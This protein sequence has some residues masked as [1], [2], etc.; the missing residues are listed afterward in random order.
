MFESISDSFGS[1]FDR[2]RGKRR[3]SED[4]IREAMREI[5]VALLEA[6]VASEV[7]RSFVKSVT[8]KSVDA[9]VV[10]SV[11]P[12]EMVV[13]IV[14]DELVELLGGEAVPL[15]LEPKGPTVM[16]LC[17]LQGAGKTTT[18]GKLAR[19]LQEEGHKVLLVGADVQRPAAIEQLKVL[20]EQIG[21]PVYAEAGGDPV[22]V[23]TRS[24]SV[25][26]LHGADVILL[27]TA[28]RL[29]VDE[30]L[31]QEL[32]SIVRATGP[33]EVLLVLDAMTGQDAVASAE[34]FSRRLP[35]SGAILTK[36]DGDARGGAAL[37]LRQVAGVPIKFVGVGEKLD[38]LEEFHP[39]RMAGRILGMGDVVS[40]V[41]KAQREVDEEEQKAMQEKL[42]KNS[43]TLEDFQK[44]LAQI[45]RMGS[46]KDLLGLI[47]GLGRQVRQID[48]DESEFQRIEA[49][50][51]SMTR[52]ERSEPEIIDT[53]RRERIASG[54]GTSPADVGQLLKQ[55]REMKK[56]IGKM[57][58]RG[59]LGNLLG[60]GMADLAGADEG[61]MDGMPQIPGMSGMAGMAGM[62]P[63]PMD[64]AKIK[65]RRAE[66]KKEKKKRKKNRKRRK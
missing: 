50:I 47:P 63:A 28:G 13:K 29:H 37:S 56:M 22:E 25:A 9:E 17:G 38:A 11:Q 48:V 6:D 58:R 21:A 54:S 33:R 45:R 8:E 14:H 66:R 43:F 55:F 42:L 35:L 46:I 49:V 40:L 4:A 52:Q 12:G 18:I 30:P 60:G 62:G 65:K 3:L 16:M 5:R 39:D 20:G 36:L 24:T 19:T 61:S 34:A 51:Q 1:V 59:M 41:E 15:Q 31:M 23:C 2:L 27:D 7:V 32:E 10:K 64:S 57:G 53:S 44:Q 26:E